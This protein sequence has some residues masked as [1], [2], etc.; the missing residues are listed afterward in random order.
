M[1]KYRIEKDK[2]KYKIRFV[3]I[4]RS[5]HKYTIE[6]DTDRIRIQGKISTK[7]LIKEAINWETS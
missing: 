4:V 1:A 5:R 7:E 6:R 2:K 3:P